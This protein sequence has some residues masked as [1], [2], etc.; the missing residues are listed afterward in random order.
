MA[1]NQEAD[2]TEVEKEVTVVAYSKDEDSNPRVREWAEKVSGVD[3]S[4][5]DTTTITSYEM[6]VEDS[7]GRD[8]FRKE[9]GLFDYEKEKAEKVSE[10]LMEKG[11]ENVRIEKDITENKS[12][13]NSMNHASNSLVEFLFLLLP[14][15][16]EGGV[17]KYEKTHLTRWRDE[18]DQ[19]GIG[20]RYKN[21]EEMRVLSKETK[22]EDDD[23]YE[24]MAERPCLTFQI[25]MTAPSRGHIDTWTESVV[26]EVT[27]LLYKHPHIGKVR[28]MNCVT[29]TQ[30]EGECYNL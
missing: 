11:V 21:F 9:M 3:L 16:L 24:T 30:Q 15:E 7:S 4:S 10:D 29:T 27:K 8:L 28:Y 22:R 20:L 5:Y 13:E 26:P 12:F 23:L 6:V 1:M 19:W 25:K 2:R 14:D 17:S 18:M